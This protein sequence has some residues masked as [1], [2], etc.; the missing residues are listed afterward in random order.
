VTVSL[1]RCDNDER[2]GAILSRSGD[3]AALSRAEIGDVIGFLKTM[4]DGYRD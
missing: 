2:Q 3:N 1:Q 4:T